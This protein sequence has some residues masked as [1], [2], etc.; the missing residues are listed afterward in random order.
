MVVGTTQ[1]PQDQHQV[2]SIPTSLPS[3]QQNETWWKLNRKNRPQANSVATASFIFI[4]GGINMAWKLGLS[5]NSN[6]GFLLTERMVSSWFEGALIGAIGGAYFS[7]YFPKKL[8]MWM[9]SMLVF[10]SGI[11]QLTDPNSYDTIMASRY[12]NGLAVGFIFPLT[13]VLIGE[14]LIRPLRG[15]HACSVDTISFSCGIFIQIIYPKLFSND[16]EAPFSATQMYGVLNIICGIIAFIL[17]TIYLIESPIFYLLREDERMALDALKAL[18]KPHELTAEIYE[19]LEEHKRY[20]AE[21][22][23]KTFKENAIYGIPAL[24]KLCFYRS[25]MALGFSYFVNFAFAYSSLVTAEPNTYFYIHIFYALARLLGPLI[26]SFTLDSLGRKPIMIIGFF[27]STILAFKVGAIFNNKLNYLIVERMNTVKYVLVF[28]QLF[29]SMSMASSSA[30]LS[31]A[32]PL[33][34]KR[35]YLTIVF[36][37]E[38]LVHIIINSCKDLFVVNNLFCISDY[39]ITLGSLSLVF[40]LMSIFIMPETKLCSLR[41]C[42][43]KFRKFINF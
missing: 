10:I 22:K 35:H 18:Q 4:S 25:F 5:V 21:S 34:V 20:L 24:L 42:L 6:T 41:E 29:S 26:A 33:P 27:G 23:E 9:S 12:L 31:E 14:E 15:F 28:F 36:M 7:K 39:F 38:M 40:L 37:V 11:L 3:T 8:L 19:Q 13:F 2:Y 1:H 17:T 16:P 32:F 43:P 30:Y